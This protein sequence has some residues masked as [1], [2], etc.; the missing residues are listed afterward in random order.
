MEVFSKNNATR[1][2]PPQADFKVK[3]CVRAGAAFLEIEP[4]DLS[5]YTICRRHKTPRGGNIFK[6]FSNRQVP[7]EIVCDHVSGRGDPLVM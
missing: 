1:F 7:H 3:Q 6:Y 5:A 2:F 4:V